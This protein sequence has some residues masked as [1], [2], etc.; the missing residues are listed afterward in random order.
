ME[1]DHPG[2]PMISQTRKFSGREL[3]CPDRPDNEIR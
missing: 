3:P 1:Q 2:V